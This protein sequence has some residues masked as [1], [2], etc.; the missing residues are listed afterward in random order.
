[1]SSANDNMEIIYILIARSSKIVL[2]DYTDYSGNFQQIALLLLSKVKK[3]TK[4][5]IIYDEYKFFSDD[6]KDITFLCMGKNIETELAFNFIS[7]MKKK[8]LL[9][10]DYE[11]QIKKAFSYELKEFTE[12][13]K[14]LYFSY[15]SNPIS[16]IK[17]LE[18]SI[19]KTNDILMQNVQ[20]LLER[21]AKLN[22]I[23]QK[24]ERL[25]G[26]SSN[27]MKN[28][29]EIKRRQKLKRFKYYIIIGGII[30]L[31]ILLLYARFS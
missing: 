6:E 2:C 14:K 20:E 1:M 10:Y 30:F 8:F 27:F 23:A 24:S 16:K 11:T 5:E 7:D 28:I 15:K 21:D 17:M 22:L 18:N 29:Q 4:C 31:G 26:D 12:E 25:M 13:I 3:N 9:S 19:S